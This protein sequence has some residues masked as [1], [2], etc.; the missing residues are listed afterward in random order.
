MYANGSTP[1]NL[2]FPKAVID[3]I[4]Y[5]LK[6]GIVSIACASG[7][8]ICRVTRLPVRIRN[9]SISDVSSVSS[10]DDIHYFIQMMSVVGIG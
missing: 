6:P 2:S 9:G 4:T 1:L 3:K 7:S 5:P 10:F 8:Q